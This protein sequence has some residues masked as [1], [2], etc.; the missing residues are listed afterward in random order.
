MCGGDPGV[1]RRTKARR[2]LCARG[3]GYYRLSVGDW[4]V[5][6]RVADDTVYILNVGRAA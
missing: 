3:S 2:R 5:L 1:R 6:Y 4:R